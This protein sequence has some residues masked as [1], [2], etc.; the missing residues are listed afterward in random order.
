MPERDDIKKKYDKS[1]IVKKNSTVLSVINILIALGIIIFHLEDNY[2]IVFIAIIFIV[3]Y[4]VFELINDFGLKYD[5]ESLRRKNAIEVGF[6]MDFSNEKTEG[7]YSNDTPESFQKYILN[8]FESCFY[9]NSIVEKMK[10][11]SIIKLIAYVV[12][13]ILIIVF[14]SD[15]QIVLLAAEVIFSASLLPKEAKVLV[16]MHKIKDIYKKM[17]NALITMGCNDRKTAVCLLSYAIEYESIKA[18]FN[19][20]L[21]ERLYKRMHSELETSFEEIKSK[22]VF[23]ISLICQCC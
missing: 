19:V 13:F 18:Y 22:I 11:H 21:S 20:S 10:T 23:N 1:V 3:L 6:G 9:T 5:A 7:Y 2:L 16:F 12:I 15:K 14:F 17:Y 4:F 8:I